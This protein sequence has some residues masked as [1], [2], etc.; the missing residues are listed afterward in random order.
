MGAD[1]VT[2]Y[3]RLHRVVGRLRDIVIIIDQFECV[4][5]AE[6]GGTGGLW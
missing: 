2:R 5:V 3:R 1:G 4:P 6:E